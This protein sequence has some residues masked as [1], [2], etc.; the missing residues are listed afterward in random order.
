MDVSLDANIIL[1]GPRML[2]NAFHNLLA[3]LRK[4]DSRLVSSK[5]VFDERTNSLENS[6]VS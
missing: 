1:N 6:L 4:T 3:Y 5:I 2:G